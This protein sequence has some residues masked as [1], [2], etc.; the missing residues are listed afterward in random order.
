MG[1]KIHSVSQ[2]YGVH[3]WGEG[4]FGINAKGH[5]SVCPRLQAAEELDLY[6]IAKEV[7]AADLQWPVLLRFTDILQQ[8][9]QWLC[10]AFNEAAQALDY[11][12]AYRAIYPIKVN[13]Q[14]S[15]VEQIVAAGT[16]HV[17]LEAGSKPEL[18]AVLAVAQPGSVVICNG[19]KD[20]EYVRLALIGQQLGH[21]LYIVLEKPSELALVMREAQAMEIQPLLGV[22]VRLATVAEGKW[23]NSGGDNAK[24]GLSAA[25]LLVLVEQL[26]QAGWLQSLVLL[27]SHIGSQIPDLADIARGVAEAARYYVA[28]H[29]AGAPLRI[30]DVGGGLGVDYE[31]SSSTRFCS[32]NYQLS[33]YAHQIL[34]S[35]AQQ[36]RC[37]GIAEPMILSE[38]GRALTAHHAVLV[39]EVV[40]RERP[41]TSADTITTP[42]EVPLMQALAALYGALGERAPL[43]LW[44]E[45]QQY[46]AQI[47]ELFVRGG[48]GL[49]QRAQ[50]EQYF[51]RLADGLRQHVDLTTRGHQALLDT[52]NDRLAERVFV[53]FSVFQS[54]P[55]SWAIEQVFPVMPLHRLQETPDQVAVLQDVTCD[56]DGCIKHYV[57]QEGVAPTLRLHPANDEPYL[58]GIFLVGAYQEIL[59]DMHNLFG[60]TDT[61]N[62]VLDGQGGYRLTE[63]EPGDRVD[64]LLRYVHF[65]PPQMLQDYQHKLQ[66]S[67]LEIGLQADYFAVLKAALQG[68]T[69]LY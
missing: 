12:G 11:A 18:M 59:G 27:H 17:G 35:V 4:H 47:Q 1:A 37:A 21:E 30:L 10:R 2:H 64:D 43:P 19:Y 29:E 57:T 14:R 56:S 48:L 39:T 16:D 55:D 13:Q 36:C 50:A 34:E 32:M 63:L 5:V 25:Q 38:S 51:Y 67:G 15:V 68:S 8:R 46:F 6:Q 40:G 42:S 49:A 60:D 62:V 9:V 3:A 7:R 53:N 26:Q 28:L 65:D 41:F 33:A 44:Q 20:R 31:G 45:A 23:Q 58:L 69:Y 22:R 52:L 61:V 66:Q 24:F 54:I